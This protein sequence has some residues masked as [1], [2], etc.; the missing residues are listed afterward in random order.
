MFRYRN[1]VCVVTG[2]TVAIGTIF[3]TVRAMDER[4]GRIIVSRP[5]DAR[6]EAPERLTFVERKKCAK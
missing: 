5:G 3:Y 1:G 2:D 4:N 6:S